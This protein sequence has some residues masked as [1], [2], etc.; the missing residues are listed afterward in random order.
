MQ[1]P[2]VATKGSPAPRESPATPSPSPKTPSSSAP[3]TPQVP[4]EPVPEGPPQKKGRGEPRKKAAKDLAA[5]S[6]LER[7]ENLRT[8]ILKK[9]VIAQSWRRRSRP[10]N[11]VLVWPKS[12]RSF[13]FALSLHPRF[14]ISCLISCFLLLMFHFAII[15]FVL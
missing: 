10:C 15:F 13:R 6:P 14:V 4:V 3:S 9:K 12:C 5:C 7:G 2:V 8:Q 1:P 11:L